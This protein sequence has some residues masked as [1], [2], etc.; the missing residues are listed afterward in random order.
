MCLL[1]LITFSIPI[2]P[3]VSS[4][5]FSLKSS[6]LWL[7]KVLVCTESILATSWIAKGGIFHTSKSESPLMG[8]N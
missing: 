1:E 2:C 5:E 4:P 7:S 8:E 3:S 6:V